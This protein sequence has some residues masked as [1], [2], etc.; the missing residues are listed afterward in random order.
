MTPSFSLGAGRTTN[1][2]S[3]APTNA[4]WSE[5][6]QPQFGISEGAPEEI[7]RAVWTHSM[8]TTT[9]YTPAAHAATAGR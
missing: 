2:A 8:S 1:G 9:S 7:A 4:V 6:P 5:L 3:S